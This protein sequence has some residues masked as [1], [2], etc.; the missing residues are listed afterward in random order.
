M[1]DLRGYVHSIETFGTVDGPGIRCVIFLQGCPL[2]CLYC[3]NPDTRTVNGEGIKYS[4]KELADEISK[5]KHFFDASGGGVTA[6]GGEPALQPEFL[7]EFFK[8]CK[9]RGIHTA[10]DTSGFVD[11]DSVEA[12]L[13]YTDLVLL[14]IKHLNEEKC[15]ELTGKSNRRAL[16]F[17]GLLEQKNIP[18]IVRQVLVEGWTDSTQYIDSL[19]VF[20]K[21]YSCINKVE[22]L[23]FHKMGEHKWE[24][25]GLKSPFSHIASYPHEKACRIQKLME[26]AI[27]YRYV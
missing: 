5:Y 16:D 12:F 2:R 1:K 11:M 4:P 20:L 22:A 23:P 18:V 8:E 13:P 6:S 10:L 9:N 21:Q 14:D 19:I 15:I 7:G 17:L 27:Q 24:A 25:M 26:E 3:H